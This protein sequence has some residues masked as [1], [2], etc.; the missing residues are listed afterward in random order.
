M[1]VILSPRGHLGT[2][3][4]TFVSQQWGRVWACYWLE[5]QD[6]TSQATMH[7][8]APA[9]GSNLA[10]NVTSAKIEKP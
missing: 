6:A 2:S 9:T 10:E 4:D 5:V 8:A 7:R 1:G 3:G